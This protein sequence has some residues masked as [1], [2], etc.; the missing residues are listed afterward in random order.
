MSR[1]GAKRQYGEQ[2]FGTLRVRNV[3]AD[4]RL[5]DLHEVIARLR[6]TNL[7]LTD[8]LLAR[9]FGEA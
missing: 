7:F 4:A 9:L 2:T 6:T 1:Q 3:A 8:E 5:L